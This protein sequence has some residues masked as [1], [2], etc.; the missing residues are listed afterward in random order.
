M[1]ASSGKQVHK[2][3][4]VEEGGAEGYVYLGHH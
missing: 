2:H 3:L 4:L 1:A